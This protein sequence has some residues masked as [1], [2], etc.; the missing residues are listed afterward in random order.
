MTHL[1][2]LALT[3]LSIAWQWLWPVMLAGAAIGAVYGL[4]AGF[5]NDDE[6]PFR[7]R[8]D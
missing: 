5:T 8:S 4:I 7:R 6:P 1:F 2:A 3:L